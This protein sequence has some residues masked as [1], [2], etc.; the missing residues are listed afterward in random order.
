MVS[1]MAARSWT[2]C[3]SCEVASRATVTMESTNSSKVFMIVRSRAGVLLTESGAL[4]RGGLR[5]QKSQRQCSG[6]Q[7]WAVPSRATKALGALFNHDAFGWNA[8]VG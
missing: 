3:A 4:K 2:H 8:H 1:T 6:T 7:R 5:P